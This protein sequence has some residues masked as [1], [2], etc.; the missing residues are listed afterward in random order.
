M[1][2]L[3]LQ[4]VMSQEITQIVMSQNITLSVVKKKRRKN[5]SKKTIFHPN[6]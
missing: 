4:I 1:D 2:K 3:A 6:K 5:K